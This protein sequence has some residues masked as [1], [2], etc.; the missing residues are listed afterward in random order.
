MENFLTLLPC[1]P[2]GIILK[3]SLFHTYM[4]FSDMNKESGPVYTKPQ[5]KRFKLINVGG[6]FWI[7]QILSQAWMLLAD[8]SN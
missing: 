8:R 2:D 4:F 6:Q 1:T 7:F 5:Y 3:F